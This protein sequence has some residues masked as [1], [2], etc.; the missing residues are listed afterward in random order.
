MGLVPGVWLQGGGW[1]HVLSAVGLPPLIPWCC[2]WCRWGDRSVPPWAL[3][4]YP[5]PVALAAA[6]WVSGP[7]V[8]LW[9]P[10]AA[11]SLGMGSFLGIR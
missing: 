4:L 6:W 5:G 10:L 8:A 3:G 1:G 9:E 2:L 11:V 7:L